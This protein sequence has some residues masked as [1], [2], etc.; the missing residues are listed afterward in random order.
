MSENIFNASDYETVINRLNLLNTQSKREWGTMN[1]NEMLI[2]C[3]IQL[4]KALG[5]MPQSQ[6]EGP[7]FYR[8]TL[9]RWLALYA[10]AWP[11][12]SPTPSAMNM[13]TNHAES[14]DFDNAKLELLQLLQQ[15]QASS[16][17]LPHPFFG[18]LSHKDWGRLIWKHLD[19][20]LR[21]FGK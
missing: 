15:V 10:L 18:A 14:K 3:G 20:H 12:G 13:N 16:N 8:T 7:F 9:G 6:S 1:P 17:L 21:Q 2:H 19:H 11:K 5:L 4:K